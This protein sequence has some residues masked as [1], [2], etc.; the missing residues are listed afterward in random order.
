MPNETYFPDSTQ[1]DTMNVQLERIANAVIGNLSIDGLAGIQRAVRAGMAPELFPI[2]S[3]FVV[4]N[5]VYGDRIAEVMAHNYLKSA[6]DANAHTMT[7]RFKELF[8]TLQFDAP[9]AFYYADE[10]IPAGAY[11]FTITTTYSSWAAGTYT[12]TLANALP[13][14]G[15]LCISGNAGTALTSLKVVAY[16]SRTTTT[17]TEQVNIE[18]GST[19]TDLGALGNT[20]NHPQRV[21]YGSNNYKESAIRQFLNSSAAAGSVWSP[22]TKYD[23]PPTWA[24]SQAGF[25]TG[26]DAEFLAVVGEVNLPCVANN[27]FESQ[28]SSTPM[29]TAYTLHD[30]FYLPSRCE[31]FGS[32]EISADESVLFPF[33]SGASNT[34]RIGYLNGSPAAQWLRT[35]NSDYADRVRLVYSDGSMYHNG[36]HN[37]NAHAP[38]FTIV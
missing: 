8:P 23:R 24:A 19:G 7:C 32:K 25:L 5:S 36:A 38:A 17:A 15:Q 28:D 30:K 35:P 2:G 9:E 22:K 4:E 11:K 21:S 16:A 18:S 13:K 31:I 1:F 10:A 6:H 14:G 26:F 33:Y 12:F 27:T 34:D 3:Q 20:L 37:A 29:N